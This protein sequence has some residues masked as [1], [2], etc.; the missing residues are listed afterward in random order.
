MATLGCPDINDVLSW[1]VPPRLGGTWDV[2]N[3][4]PTSLALHVDFQMQLLHQALVV[5]RLRPGEPLPRIDLERTPDGE[6]RVLAR[7][8]VDAHVHR[9][10]WSPRS[11]L[12]Y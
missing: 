1:K 3:L 9:S 12:T 2:E 6:T 7:H 10:D 4:Q 11:L 8:G 5:H